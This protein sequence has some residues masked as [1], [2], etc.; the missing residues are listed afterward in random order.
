MQ[1]D[2]LIEIEAVATSP[3]G[4]EVERD[5]V[6]QLRATLGIADERLIAAG[7]ADLLVRRGRAA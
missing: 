3:G 7:Y 4:L 6:E 5:R 1:P 2:F